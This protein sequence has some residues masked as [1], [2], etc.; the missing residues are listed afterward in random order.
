M[1][2]AL[3]SHKKSIVVGIRPYRNKI[4]LLFLQDVTK[5]RGRERERERKRKKREREYFQ[6]YQ[7]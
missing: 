4:S 3:K 5:N 2:L 7:Q 6:I 1:N